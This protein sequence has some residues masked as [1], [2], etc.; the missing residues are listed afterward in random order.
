LL[1]WDGSLVEQKRD[2]NGML[3][4]RN[5]YVDPATGRFTQEDPI[6]LAGGLNL[7]GFAN[8]DP[9]T[10]SDPFGLC[11]K[12][13]GGDGRTTWLTDCP[14]GSVGRAEWQKNASGNAESGGIDD[15]IFFFIGGAEIKGAEAGVTLVSR[16]ARSKA[17]AR[18][19]A[20]LE[21]GVQLSIDRL[22][23]KLAQ[24]NLNPGIGSNFLFKGIFEARARDGARVYFRNMGNGTI[25][26]L[27]KSTKHTQDQVI[28]ILRELYQ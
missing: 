1:A 24:G 2:G 9:V 25:E 8:G 10:Y 14:E 22:T 18:I 7:Y 12:D 11:P 28:R 26:I 21:G 6:G 23:A 3:Y 20:Q 27:A 4:R 15:I 19:A 17:L 13:K 16:I 5:R